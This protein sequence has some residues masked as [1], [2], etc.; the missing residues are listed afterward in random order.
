MAES[1]LIG[2]HC[3][4]SACAQ[5]RS[6]NIAI[7]ADEISCSP[8]HIQVLLFAILISFFCS[9][10]HRKRVQ[11]VFLVYITIPE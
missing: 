6:S 2:K 8:S 11:K 9:L 3:V 1:I 4:I 10:S 5:S 7:L